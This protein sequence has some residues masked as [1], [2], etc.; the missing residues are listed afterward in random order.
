MTG[1]L[2]RTT[3]AFGL[4]ARVPFL[5]HELVELAA[6]IPVGFCLRGFREKYILRRAVAGDLPAAI[7]W[8][9]KR[10]LRAPVGAW[11]RGRLPEFAQALL[12]PDRLRE[13]GYFD[14]AAVQA[15]VARHRADPRSDGQ[16]LWAVLGVQ[17]W[18]EL[19]RRPGGRWAVDG[20]GAPRQAVAG[21]A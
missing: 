12:S 15:L 16:L 13:D 20:R 17:L 3:M 14:A 6:E 7:V 9:R 10:P 21:R 2:D 19:F 11:L 5:D 4:E 1:S 18:H 8:R